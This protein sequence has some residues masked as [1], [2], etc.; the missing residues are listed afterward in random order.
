MSEDSCSQGPTDSQSGTHGTS[1]RDNSANPSPAASLKKKI[2]GRKRAASTSEAPQEIKRGERTPIKTRGAAGRRAR[3]K[4]DIDSDRYSPTGSSSLDLLASRHQ[5]VTH[6][7]PL[8]NMAPNAFLTSVTPVSKYNFVEPIDISLE[9]DKRIQI[10]QDRL[11]ELRRTYM[12]IKSEVATI[13]RRRRKAKKKEKLNASSVDSP[14]GSKSAL[15]GTVSNEPSDA[16]S[17]R[18]K[19]ILIAP[20]T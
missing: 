14:S 13:E 1:K 4:M 10:L 20:V 5:I 6:S 7:V 12:N 3:A 17:S 2:R 15:D 9:A 11:Q 8:T 16:D 18:P 19:Q